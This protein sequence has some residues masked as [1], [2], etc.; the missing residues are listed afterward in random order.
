MMSI[1]MGLPQIMGFNH[2]AT[3]ACAGCSRTFSADVRFQILGL[4]D[5]IREGE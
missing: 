2:A 4:F 5:F 1:S 3:T